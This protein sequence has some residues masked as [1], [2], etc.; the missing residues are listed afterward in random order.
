[1]L[2]LF[3]VWLWLNCSGALWAHLTDGGKWTPSLFE[4]VLILLS[5]LTVTTTL[6]FMLLNGASKN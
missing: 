5:P 1:M 3:T 6:L 2:T 4:W